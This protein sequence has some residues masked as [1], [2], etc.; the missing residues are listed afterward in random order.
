M[1]VKSCK[2]AGIAVRAFMILGLPGETHETVAATRD[3]LD[4]AQPTSIGLGPLIPYPGSRIWEHPE[5]F[6]IKINLPDDEEEWHYRGEPGHYNVYV[7]TSQ[8]TSKQIGEY[9]YEIEKDYG[10]L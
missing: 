9:I 8:L 5:E 3:W 1:A 2:D 10:I 4:I 6:D 7:S